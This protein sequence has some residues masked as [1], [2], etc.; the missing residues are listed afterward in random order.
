MEL[1]YTE[2][3]KGFRARAREWLRSNAPKENRAETT[4]PQARVFDT[5]RQRTQGVHVWR[6]GFSRPDAAPLYDVEA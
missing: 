3:E 5:A 2:D 6:R 1:A 4:G